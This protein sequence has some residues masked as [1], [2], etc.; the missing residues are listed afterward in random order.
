MSYLEPNF[1]AERLESKR[2][3]VSPP[4]IDFG[5]GGA[6]CKTSTCCAVTIGNV[7]APKLGRTGGIAGILPGVRRTQ[8]GLSRGHCEDQKGDSPR[9]GPQGEEEGEEGSGSLAGQGHHGKE[10]QGRGRV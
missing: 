8:T 5:I 2:A 7:G 1:K 10:G 3:G 4:A 6:D 9:A